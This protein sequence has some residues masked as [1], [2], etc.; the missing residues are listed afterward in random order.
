MEVSSKGRFCPSG[1]IIH[2]ES[3]PFT[4]FT[5][6]DQTPYSSVIQGEGTLLFPDN[7]VCRP[8]ARYSPPVCSVFIA[9]IPN[10]WET[11]AQRQKNDNRPSPSIA[12]EQSSEAK[13]VKAV[14]GMKNIQK[15]HSEE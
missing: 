6:F 7:G 13:K 2:I 12:D 10:T 4:G 14:K 9:R 15:R 11:F 5:F 8:Y 1:Y 3:P